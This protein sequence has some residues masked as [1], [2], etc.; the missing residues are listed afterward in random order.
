MCNK[1]FVGVT[2]T[3]QIRSANTSDLKQMNSFIMTVSHK[4]NVPDKADRIRKVRSHQ[5]GA[6]SLC[7]PHLHYNLILSFL[8][9]PQP[10]L[11]WCFPV[12]QEKSRCAQRLQ[13]FTLVI[14]GL[15]TDWQIHYKFLCIKQTSIDCG[16]EVACKSEKRC[17]YLH[18]YPQ[19]KLHIYIGWMFR[20]FSPPFLLSLFLKEVSYVHQDCIY[21]IK[22]Q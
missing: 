15:V 14:S 16:R 7:P 12:T 9:H 8:M 1:G 18:S 2:A 3:P 19:Y 11:S 20:I 17:K 10:A 6:C 22:I 5:A 21:L 13:N 4:T